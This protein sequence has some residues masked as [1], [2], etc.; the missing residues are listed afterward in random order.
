MGEVAVVD[1]AQGVV[2]GREAVVANFCFA[3]GVD[4]C[5]GEAAVAF[6]KA[7]GAFGR[8]A[9]V[10]DY[11]RGV[12]D[13]VAARNLLNCLGQLGVSGGACLLRHEGCRCI[14]GCDAGKSRHKLDSVRREAHAHLHCHPESTSVLKS[15]VAG[16]ARFSRLTAALL[17]LNLNCIFPHPRRGN[18]RSGWH[19]APKVNA[20][21]WIR[22]M[23]FRA[24]SALEKT[25][26]SRLGERAPEPT[27]RNEE[28][29]G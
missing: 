9:V 14:Y 15:C 25:V 21:A 24:R 22:S 16:N 17:P 10:A 27:R 6:H 7:D 3:G 11:R 26:S 12:S 18:L 13:H 5:G 20:H 23:D 28:S 8:C 2:G 19:A 29:Y 1:R 4:G